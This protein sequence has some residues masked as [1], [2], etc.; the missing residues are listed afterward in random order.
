MRIKVRFFRFWRMISWPAANGMRVR[1]PLQRDGSPVVNMALDCLR[2]AVRTYPLF[3]QAFGESHV[4]ILESHTEYVHDQNPM[5]AEYIAPLGL[6]RTD[7]HVFYRKLR[8]AIAENR[9]G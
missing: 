7:S 5:K 3:L 2:R 9:A 6:S 4:S 8:A 1:E